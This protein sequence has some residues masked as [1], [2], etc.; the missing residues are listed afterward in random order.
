MKLTSVVV[1]DE[2][3]DTIAD[4]VSQH[5]GLNDL[6]DP[7]ASSDVSHV[8]QLRAEWLSSHRKRLLSL[9]AS[10]LMQRRLPAPGK[11]TRQASALNRRG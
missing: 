5:Y 2:R 3:I 7:S 9:V 1:L 4:L 6:G 8:S 11:L 10:P